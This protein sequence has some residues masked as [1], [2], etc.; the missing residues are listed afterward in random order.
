M[1]TSV[2]TLDTAEFD[3]CVDAPKIKLKILFYHAAGHYGWLYPAALQ[4]KTYIDLLYP[5][6]AQN[7]EWLV[8]IQKEMSAIILLHYI[9][10]NLNLGQLFL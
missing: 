9:K 6:L 4:L 1:F 7:I 3:S 5:D 10:P 8:P 2:K